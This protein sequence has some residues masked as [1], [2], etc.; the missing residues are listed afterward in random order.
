MGIVA[1][2][3]STMFQLK[4]FIY[5]TIF[6]KLSADFSDETKK[7]VLDW[8]P[9]VWIHPEDPFLPS[10]VD[11]YL[12]YNEIR[13]GDENLMQPHP[14][15]SSIVVGPETSDYHMNTFEDLECVHCYRDH[16]Y[17]Q[18]IELVKSIAL[19][20]EWND[21]CNTIDVS[22]P[23]FYPYNYGKDVCIGF[24]PNGHCNGPIDGPIW[25]FGNHVSDWEH[26]AIRFQNN[27]PTDMYLAAHG[28]GAKYAYNETNRTFDFYD[29]EPCCFDPE[30]RIDGS[31]EIDIDID[32]P[33]TVYLVD[34]HPEVF[35]ANGSHGTWGSEGKHT[36]L[37]IVIHLDDI[38]ERGQAWKIWEN[39]ELI[40]ASKPD[41][42]YDGDLSWINF[43]GRWGNIQQIHCELE[44]IVGE[45]GLVGGVGGPGTDFGMNHFGDPDC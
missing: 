1:Y 5:L 32:Y 45:C 2:M 37:H 25:T 14:N 10:N 39:M 21:E 34:G 9:L 19:V 16:F 44:P 26:Q 23:Q 43:Q 38:C 31:P 12:E 30:T 8:A 22:Y 11:F 24:D 7:L 42:F 41:D 6:G 28:F 4:L 40:D 20:K 29:G 3:S 27:V 18:P 13:D 17:G 15:V 36:Y 33:K 35:S